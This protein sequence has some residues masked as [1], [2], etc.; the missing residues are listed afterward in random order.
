MAEEKVINVMTVKYNV[1]IS[2]KEIPYFRGAVIAA[3]GRDTDILF[4][5]HKGDEKYRYSY[6]LVQY[7]RLGGKACVVLVNDAIMDADF[8][9]NDTSTEFQIGNRATGISIEKV[10][11]ESCDVSLAGE[12]ES[13]KLHNWLPLNAENYKRYMQQDSMIERLELLQHILVGNIISMYK[14]LGITVTDE[15]MVAITNMST[16]RVV[17]HKG[18]KLLSFDIDF[19]SNASLPNNIGLGKNASLGCGVIERGSNI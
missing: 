1:N 6:P 2:R 12:Q 13:Y 18:V 10:L 15:I 3:I 19:K 16:P 5:N 9:L 8:L 4:H 7:K 17:E 14:G 11:T